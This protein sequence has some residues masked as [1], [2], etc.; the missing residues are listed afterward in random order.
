MAA[1]LQSFTICLKGGPLEVFEEG[2]V[3][4]RKVVVMKKI[5][6]RGKFP[7][8]EEGRYGIFPSI[9][10]KTCLKRTFGSSNLVYIVGAR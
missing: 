1:K 2:H 10:G 3:Y 5:S 8:K 6:K 4:S 7:T 9:W